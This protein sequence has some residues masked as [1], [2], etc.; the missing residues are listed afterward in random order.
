MSKYFKHSNALVESSNI[1]NGTRVWAFVHILPRAK[2]GENCNICDHCFIENDV[3]VGDNVTIKSGIYLWDGVRIEKNVFLGP[4][5]VFTNDLMPR[6]KKYP[7]KFLGTI[8]EEGASIGANSV[9][10]AGNKIGKYAM[11]GAGSVVTKDIP[12]Y[13]LAY[14]NPVRV[15]YNI[16]ECT[17]KLEFDHIQ[18][19]TCSCGKTYKKTNEEVIKLEV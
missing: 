7:D 8:V 14:G 11:I 18:M 6:S 13:S 1:G 5:V 12:A 10:V 4:N 2:I 16:C 17:E 15:K 19:A 3:I 9:I